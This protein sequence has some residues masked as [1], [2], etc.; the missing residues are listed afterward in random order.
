MAIDL[1]VIGLG[2][3]GLPLADAAVRGGLSVLGF[4]VNETVV[5]NLND[6]H[7]H[8]DDL[9]DADVRRMLAVGFRATAAE[10]ELADAEAI[11]VCV[12]TP[13]TEDAGPDL[14][15]VRAATNTVA[16]HL[17]PGMLVVLESTTYPGTTDEVVR[18]LLEQNGLVAGRDF[19]LAFSPERIDPGNSNF[20]IRNTPKVVGGHTAECTERASSF[21][22]RFIDTVVQAGGTREAETAK[23]LE[24]TYRHVN[25]ALVNEMARFCHELGIDLWDVIRCTS[26]KPFG[27]QPFYPGPGVG[28]HCIPI[29]PN[30]LSHNVRAKLGYPFRFVEL[31]QEINAT[32]PDYVARRAQNMLN[33]HG[34]AIKGA[35]ILLLGV[36]Y[37]PDIADQRESPAVAVARRLRS[38]GASLLFHDPYVRTWSLE[39]DTLTR[40]DDLDTALQT[41][42]LTVVLQGHSTYDGELIAAKA[43]RVLDTRGITPRSPTVEYM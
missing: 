26:T 36:T 15:A 25:I 11:V 4:D 7:S 10:R 12:P 22:G 17:R 34:H 43:I 9:S 31:A 41:A 21:Y 38:L 27:F 19:N 37:K 28:G 5:R 3:V 13:L 2:Y 32:M 16:R 1:A 39:G 24:N 30:Y 33:N 40:V 23:L 35:T 29:D 18:P 42:D 20:G 6:G 14:R 8:V